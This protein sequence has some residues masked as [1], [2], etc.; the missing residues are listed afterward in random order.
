MKIEKAYIISWLG[1]GTDIRKMRHKNHLEQIQNLQKCGIQPI[2]LAQEYEKDEFIEGVT[3]IKS[4]KQPTIAD[5][6]NVLL[7]EFYKTD[8]DFG[9]FADDDCIFYE[10]KE[11]YGDSWG[12]FDLLR[13]IDYDNFK[14]VDC[15]VPIV[16]IFTPFSKFYEEN[17]A[18]L[19]SN[20]YFEKNSLMKGIHFTKNLKKEYSDPI[21]YNNKVG[22][23]DGTFYGGE[24]N[25]FAYELISKG[26]G[27]YRCRN[28]IAKENG[29]STWAVNKEVRR[30]V[31]DILDRDVF[32][33]LGIERSKMMKEAFL[34]PSKVMI[35][36]SNKAQASLADF[37]S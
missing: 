8:L 22:F 15:F 4:T 24:D 16:P 35:N 28:I 26:Y 9:I 7:E 25:F 32:K 12:I 27:V 10:G 6:R 37:L 33:L 2:V 20:L 18:L 17:K 21:Y 31:M 14:E 3:Y 11:S 1:N 19:A 29:K 30:E 5:A 34:H 36:K 13:N 23:I